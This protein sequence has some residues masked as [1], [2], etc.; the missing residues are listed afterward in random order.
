MAITEPYSPFHHVL[1]QLTGQAGNYLV[2]GKEYF[3]VGPGLVSSMQGRLPGS[4]VLLMG[5]NT[6]TQ[7]ELARAF[8]NKGASI[9]VGWTGL[10]SLVLTDTFVISLFTRTLQQHKPLDQALVDSIGVLAAIGVAN[11][12]TSVGPDQS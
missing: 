8:I 3:S 12:L 4:L 1:E 6:L 11:D 7:P 9:V 10:V 2:Q 5:C